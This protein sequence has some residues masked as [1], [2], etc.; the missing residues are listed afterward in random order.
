MQHQNSSIFNF[1]KFCINFLL[2]FTISIVMFGLVFNF[3]FE[4]YIIF[5]SEISGASKINKIITE[6]NSQE[7]PLFGSSRAE[8]IFIPDELGTNFYN[9]GISGTQDN[10]MLFFLQQEVSKK[11]NAP[12]ILNFD[13]D[14]LSNSL[15][16]IS[17]YI[18]NSNNNHIKEL[19]GNEY[20]MWFKIPFIKYYGKYELY[21]KLLLSSKIG[22]TK[23]INKG[24]Q[25]EKNE[26]TNKKFNELVV[27]RE[28]TVET[29]YNDPILLKKYLTLFQS[30]KNRLFIIIIS[31]Y[32][33]SYFKKYANYNEAISFINK[34]D[35]FP[36]V[37]VFNFAKFPLNDS[38]FINTTHLNYKGALK[39]NAILKDSLNPYITNT[40]FTK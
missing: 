21:I 15:F 1:R 17:N 19:I 32:H 11:K 5:K 38:L 29:F 20:K 4:K 31:P 37:K 24:A 10:V 40:Y 18:P 36:N 9:Y 26:L 34:M 6:D 2:P 3:L 27:Q 33:E 22:L 13:L 35:S 25:I 39:F 28:N 16:D 8:G 30:N 23:F 14:G 12:I 7:I